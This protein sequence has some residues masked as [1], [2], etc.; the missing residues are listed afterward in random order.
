MKRTADNA[1]VMLDAKPCL[2]KSLDLIN[3]SLRFYKGT[4]KTAT[5][6]TVRGI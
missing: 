3:L 6:L 2:L 5:S 4:A 1:T